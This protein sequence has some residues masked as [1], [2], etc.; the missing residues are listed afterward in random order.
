[1]NE[2]HE[3]ALWAIEQ[4]RFVQQMVAMGRTAEQAEEVIDKARQ[5]SRVTPTSLPEAFRALSH[6]ALQSAARGELFIPERTK[7]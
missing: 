2:E 1:V 5:L 7:E 6:I 3:R 4:E